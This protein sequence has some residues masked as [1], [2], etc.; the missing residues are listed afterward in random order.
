MV[1]WD[2]PQKSRNHHRRSPIWENMWE[3][4]QLPGVGSILPKFWPNRYSAQICGLSG[5]GKNFFF[6]NTQKSLPI[7]P[8]GRIKCQKSSEKKLF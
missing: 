1:C 6:Q 5:T 8:E 4:V 7:A 2:E 3:E